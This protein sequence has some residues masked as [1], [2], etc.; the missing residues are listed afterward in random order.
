MKNLLMG[1][2]L[3]ATLTSV[4]VAGGVKK[5]KKAAKVKAEN[6]EKKCDKEPAG[7]GCCMKKTQA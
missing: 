1:L 3:V 7:H 6:C 5:D 4:S 2:A